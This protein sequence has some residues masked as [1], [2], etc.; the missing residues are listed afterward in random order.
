MQLQTERATIEFL[1][2]SDFDELLDMFAEKDS[3]KYIKPHKDKTREQYIEFLESKLEVNELYKV[4]GYWV[5]REKDTNRLIGT[6]NYYPMPESS[7]YTFKHI[8]A[9]FSRSF[10]GKG[11]SKEL[12]S[13]LIQYLK[14]NLGETEILAI[15][16]SEHV[17]SKKMLARLDFKF[18]KCFEL[19]NQTLEMHKLLL[20]N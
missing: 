6:L 17:V 14:E 18:L 5:V 9:H 1:K 2:Q 10:W 19:G 4:Y 16:E 7:G 20:S 12:L 3:F 15:V 8:G 13:R 11:F